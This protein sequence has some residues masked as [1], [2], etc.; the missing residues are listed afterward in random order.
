MARATNSSGPT[1]WAPLQLLA[2]ETDGGRGWTG[3]ELQLL[4]DRAADRLGL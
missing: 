3:P 4:A 2:D 1:S